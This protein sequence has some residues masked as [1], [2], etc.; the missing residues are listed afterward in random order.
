MTIKAFNSLLLIT[1]QIEQS[2]IIFGYRCMQS[3]S[4]GRDVHMF[5][6]GFLSHSLEHDVL[7]LY[8]LP[9]LNSVYVLL[10]FLY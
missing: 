9:P 1:F 3:C 10:L 5:T 6:F 8:S 4:L 7:V 2:S